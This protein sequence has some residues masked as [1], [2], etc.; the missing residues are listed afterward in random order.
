MQISA[1]YT[2][3]D[4]KRGLNDPIKRFND[5]GNQVQEIEILQNKDQVEE[6]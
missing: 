2:M 5:E 1:S 4:S 6:E 3:E